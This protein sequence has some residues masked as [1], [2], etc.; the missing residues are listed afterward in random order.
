MRRRRHEEHG[1][2]IGIVGLG[3]MGANMAQRLTQGGHRVVAFDLS[4]QACKRAQTHGIEAV[5]SLEKLAAALKGPRVVWLMVPAGEATQKTLEG[6]RPHLARNDVVIDGGNSNYR[7]SQR[8]ARELAQDGVR[9]VDVG[10]SGGVW[11]LKEGYCLMAGGE[12]AA[13][14][15]VR[16]AL[17]TLAPAPGRGWAHVG[18]AGAGHFVKMVHNGIEYGL[19]QAYAEG[20]ELMQRKAD[21][22]LDLAAIA[23][24]WR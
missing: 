12:A 21:L 15:R 10:T 24:L 20:F 2:K 9:F 16:P 22:G 8:R 19:M 13:V 4:A 23:E 11:G 6:L 17:E 3:K 1:M 5:S 14:R 7:D 18:P